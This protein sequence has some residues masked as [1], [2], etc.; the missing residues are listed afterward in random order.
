MSSQVLPQKRIL[1]RRSPAEIGKRRWTALG[2]VAF[3]LGGVFALTGIM[4]SVLAW[5]DP[6]PEVQILGKVSS[7]LIIL[8][9]SMLVLGAHALDRCQDLERQRRVA[10]YAGR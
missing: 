10:E 5:L 1:E 4:A 9:L 2:S 3:A 8:S 7:L 6:A